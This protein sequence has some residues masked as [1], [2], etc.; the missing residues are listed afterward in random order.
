M[1]FE[2]DMSEFRRLAEDLKRAGK[3]AHRGAT[4]ATT[5]SARRLESEAKA[6]APVDTG[7]LRS[8]IGTDIEES[9]TAVVAEVG[10]TASYGAHVEDGTSRMAPQPYMA[11][12]FD[13]AVPDWLDALADV[14]RE[15]MEE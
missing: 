2:F 4:V 8:S 14:A 15:A 9:T 11:P 7:N 1:S 3:K 12:A 5:K 6:F 10:P 13:R